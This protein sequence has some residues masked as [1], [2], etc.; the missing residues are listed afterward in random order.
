MWFAIGFIAFCLFL[1]IAVLKF[2]SVMVVH[3][4]RVEVRA[5]KWLNKFR[6]MIKGK[7]NVRAD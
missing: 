2:E 1:I 5:R 4:V 3:Y 6:D 7:T